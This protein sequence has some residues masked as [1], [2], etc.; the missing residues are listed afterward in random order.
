MTGSRHRIFTHTEEKSRL[1]HT[2]N[3]VKNNVRVFHF[4]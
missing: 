3:T 4:L 2:F 1:G